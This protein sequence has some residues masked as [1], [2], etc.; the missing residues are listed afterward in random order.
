[1]LRGSVSSRTHPIRS[2]CQSFERPL[3]SSVSFTLTGQ[4]EAAIYRGFGPQL[5]ERSEPDGF[6]DAW[7]SL[8][9]K[10]GLR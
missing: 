6:A 10:I 5:R 4:F 7:S 2:G 8:R 3:E 1:M 9:S